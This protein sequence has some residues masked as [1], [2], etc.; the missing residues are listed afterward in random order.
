MSRRIVFS[1]E[2]CDALSA[3]EVHWN[4]DV[5]EMLLENGAD[6]NVQ[7]GNTYSD[8]VFCLESTHLFYLIDTPPLLD[9]HSS[10][11]L[12]TQQFCC[13]IFSHHCGNSVSLRTLIVEL[14][15]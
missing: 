11:T 14:S 4:T 7:N 12:S 15:M 13:K 9:R 8:T 3:A 6:V 10:F 1:E 5:V 2:C